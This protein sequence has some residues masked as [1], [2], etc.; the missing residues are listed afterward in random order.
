MVI[1]INQRWQRAQP[2]TKPIYRAKPWDLPDQGTQRTL[3]LD[4]HPQIINFAHPGFCS[5]ALPGRKTNS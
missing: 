3:W 4:S 1:K 2:I 5:T